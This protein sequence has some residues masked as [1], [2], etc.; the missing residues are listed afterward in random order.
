[1]SVDP[2]ALLAEASNLHRAG[3]MEQAIDAYKSAARL[4]PGS[5]DVHRMLALALLQA[6]RPKEAV[7]SARQARDLA[8]RDPNTHVLMGAGLLLAGD[9][10]KALAA[11]DQAASLHPGLLEA[12]FQ[13]GNALAALGRHSAAVARFTQALAIDPRAPE[14]LM[15][16]ATAYARLE[17]HAEALADCEKLVEMQPWVPVHHIAKANTLLE[18]G[19]LP[20]ALAAA[21]AALAL[22]PAA[23][24]ALVVVYQVA[25]AQGDLDAAAAAMVRAIETGNAPPELRVRYAHLLR[26]REQFDAALAECES[27]LRAQ[28]R[29]AAALHERAEA[30]RA[31]D[32]AAGALADADAAIAIQPQFAL[33]QLTR[34]GALGDLGHGAE[35]RGAVDRALRAA[36]KEPRV[37]FARAAQDLARGRWADGW[38]GYEQREHMLPPPFQPLPFPRWDGIARPDLLVILSEQGIGDVLHFSRLLPWLLERELPVRLMVRAG[39]VPLLKDM[40]PQVDVVADT[41]ALP[42][43]AGSIQWAPLASLPRLLGAD[44][45]HWPPAPYLS[46]RADRLAKW[47]HLREKGGLLVGLNWQGNPSRLID[48]GRSAPLAAMAPL[49]ELPGVTL[50]SLQHGP[51]SEQLAQ[52][53]FGDRIVTLGPDVDSDGI[54]LDRA[55]ILSQLDVLVTTDT[56]A[57][58]LAGALGTRAFVAL[59]AVPDWRWGEDGAF[60][61]FYPSLRLFRQS[62]AGDW[63]GPFTRIAQAVQALS[64]SALTPTG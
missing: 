20:A 61:L 53:P 21:Q 52:V 6:G 2:R 42:E 55:A 1:M 18:M 40:V 5:I 51:G 25:L 37:L 26:L 15:N 13:A 39:L 12:H 63:S 47:A 44:P 60:S 9:P 58:H 57:A 3:K 8:P 38:A 24:E 35:A 33:A 14:A 50:V 10:A 32:D 30:K 59:R 29:S 16:R 11:F 56:S 48:V 45:A 41:D 19:N 46:P 23:V 64:P 49:A 22:A 27:A 54:F 28:P 31:L 36:P 4:V 43:G 7:R 17:R 34:A 62:K